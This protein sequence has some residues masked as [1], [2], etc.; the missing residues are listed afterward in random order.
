MCGN[1]E[2]LTIPV[3]PAG[4][5]GIQG[6]QGPEGPPGVGEMGMPGPQGIPGVPGTNGTTAFK[7]VR[8]FYYDGNI[9]NLVIPYTTITSCSAIPT[10]C[11]GPSTNNLPFVDYHV[12]AWQLVVD[13]RPYPPIYNWKLV[14]PIWN[15]IATEYI[16]Y[17]VDAVT[18]DLSI[19]F[20]N[21][22]PDTDYRILIIA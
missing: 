17:T 2:G 14:Q 10:P 4:P 18:G 22:T 12:Q 9:S 1:C 6:L 21:M 8:S 19:N 7:F 20:Q 16:Q 11:V 5:Q 13:N 15:G 3:G